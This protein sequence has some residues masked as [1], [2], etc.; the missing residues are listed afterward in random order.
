MKVS[1]LYN[2]NGNKVKNQFVV[3]DDNNNKFFQSYDSVIV[4]IEN[5]IDSDKESKI[6]LDSKY[7]NYSTTTSKYRNIFLEENTKEIE[8]KIKDGIYIL[9]NLN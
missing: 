5:F 4:K 8:K 7:Y 6:Y 3:Y 1:N 9:T 2:R